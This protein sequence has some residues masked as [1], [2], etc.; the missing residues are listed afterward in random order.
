MTFDPHA[1]IAKTR[2]GALSAGESHALSVH[3][4]GLEKALH[5]RTE[6]QVATASA[7]YVKLLLDEAGEALIVVL[8][9]ESE[10]YV[11][12][13]AKDPA[14]AMHFLLKTLRAR[15][16]QVNTVGTEGAPTKADFKEIARLLKD[17]KPTVQARIPTSLEDLGL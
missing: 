6:A 14:L 3:V 2:R 17:T 13:P 4:S 8:P 1:L 9:G 15:K 7:E 10:H 12:V 16:G 11:P 5:H